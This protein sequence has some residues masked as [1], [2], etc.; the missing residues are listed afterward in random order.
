MDGNG[1]LVLLAE[2]RRFVALLFLQLAFV[3]SE[4]FVARNQAAFTLLCW[5]SNSHQTGLRGN[6][7]VI[8]NTYLGDS[9]PELPESRLYG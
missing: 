2:E 8:W 9:V 5:G 4:L 1:F 7:P 6:P 3:L